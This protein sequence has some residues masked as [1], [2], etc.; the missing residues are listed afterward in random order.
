MIHLLIR[1]HLLLYY[2]SRSPPRSTSFSVR[3][4]LPSLLI[5]LSEDELV[6]KESLEYTD[7]RK[8]ETNKEIHKKKEAL[9][10]AAKAKTRQSS[11]ENDDGNS[12]ER[13]E[14]E[15]EDN[16]E[17]KEFEGFSLE[18]EALAVLTG[19][20][21]GDSGFIDNYGQ[22]LCIALGVKGKRDYEAEKKLRLLLM[23]AKGPT[24]KLGWKGT[25][26]PFYVEGMQRL[27]GKS[28]RM[29]IGLHVLLTTQQAELIKIL[30]FDRVKQNNYGH[31]ER[32][33]KEKG[34]V[35]LV[36]RVCRGCTPQED[37]RRHTTALLRCALGCSDAIEQVFPD[38]RVYLPALR[39][40]VEPSRSAGICD[41][42]GIS[43]DRGGNII[44]CALNYDFTAFASLASEWA[45]RK[46]GVEEKLDT[47][48]GG[49]TA[50]RR[51][52]SSSQDKCRVCLLRKVQ[53][54]TERVENPTLC[55]PCEFL[56][57]TYNVA[58]GMPRNLST[59]LPFFFE[60]KYGFTKEE[61]KAATACVCGLVRKRED[62]GRVTERETYRAL[63]L[64][65]VNVLVY[66]LRRP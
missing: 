17:E 34:L 40:F 49:D 64:L 63:H 20:A 12:E 7:V 65:C 60:D 22:G 14:G 43:R 31:G 58:T 1:L 51:S 28:Y 23:M 24:W 13:S 29:A 38:S 36:E 4:P 45:V 33:A 55:H 15:D 10:A 27:F 39:C 48:R 18:Y 2:I 19:I 59:A 32:A 61:A 53:K 44:A 54:R 26:N 5:F 66:I 6:T 37:A 3:F 25:E 21:A 9:K 46:E 57:N 62:D 52:F 8:V 50:S 11:E 30:D 41:R 47:P 35:R 56:W 42:L 16:E